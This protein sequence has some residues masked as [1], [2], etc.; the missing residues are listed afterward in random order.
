MAEI[1]ITVPDGIVDRVLDGVAKFK[2]YDSSKLPSETKAQF[3]RR[4]IVE[5]VK[6]WVL[7][8]ESTTARDAQEATSDSEI[9]IT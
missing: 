4:M 3:G 5:T 6:S 8:A 9:S 7:T 2:G 1:S